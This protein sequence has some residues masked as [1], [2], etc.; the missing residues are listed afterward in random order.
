MLFRPSADVG[1]ELRGPLHAPVATL[2]LKILRG[3]FLAATPAWLR[4]RRSFHKETLRPRRFAATRV[5][6]R[7][8]TDLRYSPIKLFRL[9]LLITGHSAGTNKPRPK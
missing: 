4:G 1:F 3:K 8:Q 9:R 7:L 6:A 5:D 2:P